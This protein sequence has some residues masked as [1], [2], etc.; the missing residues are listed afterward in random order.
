MLY[1]CGYLNRRNAVGTKNR[2]AHALHSL[3]SPGELLRGPSLLILST[4]IRMQKNSPWHTFDWSTT[5]H[6]QGAAGD[7]SA[8]FE[9]LLSLSAAD[10]ERAIAA[11][12]GTLWHEGELFPA[13]LHAI[14]YLCGFLAT[15]SVLG[16]PELCDFLALLFMADAGDGDLR[17]QSR[18]AL[19][20]ALPTYLKLLDDE[21]PLVRRGVLP[22]L[23]ALCEAAPDSDVTAGIV[24]AMMRRSLE[25]QDDATLA[26]LLMAPLFAGCG[27]GAWIEAVAAYLG[28][29]VERH[30]EHRHEEHP[31][32]R[33]EPLVRCAAAMALTLTETP[34]AQVHGLRAHRVLLHSLSNQSALTDY[35][36]I[37]FARHGLVADLCACLSF[38]GS[39][40]SAETVSVMADLLAE[41]VE[42]TDAT[43]LATALIASVFFERTTLLP[44][45]ELLPEQKEVLCYVAQTDVLW[46]EEKTV[47]LMAPV[48]AFAGLPAGHTALL[49]YLSL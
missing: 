14:P 9:S 31:A 30:E 21:A 7:V 22:L 5:T 46:Q 32:L 23:V 38:F 36:L 18:V 45:T 42:P 8:I 33:R 29:V 43:E 40:R 25:E 24:A 47:A 16:K 15:P 49:Q 10:R 35:A 12:H 11:L 39:S 19:M 17:A 37:P 34:E 44:S 13:T 27:H 3:R 20:G 6:A 48:L 41:T 1:I 26:S 2:A 4:M 28:P